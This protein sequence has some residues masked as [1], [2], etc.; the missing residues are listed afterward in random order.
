MFFWPKTARSFCSKRPA[1]GLEV[2]GLI[3]AGR[4]S[5]PLPTLRPTLPPGRLKVVAAL[6]RWLLVSSSSMA[7]L[8]VVIRLLMLLPIPLRLLH[9]RPSESPESSPKAALS[10]LRPSRQ[11]APVAASLVGSRISAPS[12]WPLLFHTGSMVVP[13]RDCASAPELAMVKANIRA[14]SG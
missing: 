9:S 14:S 3:Q 8:Q 5:W 13:L 12:T 11:R 4:L 10:V 6:R 2:P 7:T 1:L